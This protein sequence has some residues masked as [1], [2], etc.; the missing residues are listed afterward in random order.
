MK[1]VRNQN[2]ISW[3]S[4]MNQMGLKSKKNHGRQTRC[5]LISQGPDKGGNIQ[6]G[7]R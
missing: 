1:L 2:K 5:L 7:L 4:L 6:Q 3:P